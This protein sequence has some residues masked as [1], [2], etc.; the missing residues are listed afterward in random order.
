M[1]DSRETMKEQA[2]KDGIEF[3]MALG[4]EVNGKPNASVVPA[5]FVDDLLDNGAAFAGFASGG[6]WQSPADGDIAYM[7]DPTPVYHGAQTWPLCSASRMLKGNCGH[8]HHKIF[9]SV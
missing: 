3:F 1:I 5:E 2:K 6:L 7:P 4:T 8:T 9:S